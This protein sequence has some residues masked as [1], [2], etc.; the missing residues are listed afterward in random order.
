MSL[1]QNIRAMQSAIRLMERAY[2][3]QEGWIATSGDVSVPVTV[4]VDP[5]IGCLVLTPEVPLP[6]DSICITHR[7]DLL[8]V[9]PGDEFTGI[10]FV[11][12]QTASVSG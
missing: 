2:F 7:D 6:G 1:E 9:E 11:S 3:D 5:E 4:T 12:R 8:W 10:A